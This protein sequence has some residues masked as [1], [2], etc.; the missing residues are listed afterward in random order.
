M[1]RQ[2]AQDVSV[3]AARHDL[4]A[5]NAS[6]GQ[7]IA[8]HRA[9]QVLKFAQC[10]AV[11]LFGNTVPL[12]PGYAHFRGNANHLV[13]DRHRIVE[14]HGLQSGIVCVFPDILQHD[15]IDIHSIRG[16]VKAVF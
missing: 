6:R 4:G 13:D 2:V 5:G 16:H 8:V 11:V 7:V 15:K 1:N 12:I 9:V 14:K 10:D 3:G